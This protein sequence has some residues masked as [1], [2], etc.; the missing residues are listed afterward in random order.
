M[1]DEEAFVIRQFFPVWVVVRE[2]DLRGGE[3]IG[4]SHQVLPHLTHTSSGVQNEARAF[5][6]ISQRSWYLMGKEQNRSGDGVKMGS[7][8]FQ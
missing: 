8:I 1:T 2:V 7:D 3:N 4:L 6:Y 5:L